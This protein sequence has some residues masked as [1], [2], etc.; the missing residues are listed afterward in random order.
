ML[1]QGL[2]GAEYV[3][4]E[5]PRVRRSVEDDSLSFLAFGH[6]VDFVL[7]RRP[8]A[9]TAVECKRSSKELDATSL[10]SFRGRYPQGEN[11][12]VCSDVTREFTR[13]FGDVG[14]RFVG[15]EGLIGA[16]TK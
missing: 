6:E 9:P 4:C 8:T 10:R 13:T 12:V 7:T 11:L 3:D 2:P 14:V 1:A 15:L 16:L 5:L